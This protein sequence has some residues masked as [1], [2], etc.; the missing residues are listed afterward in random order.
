MMQSS[1]CIM[2]ENHS[3]LNL[4]IL[5]KLYVFTSNLQVTAFQLFYKRNHL[6][7]KIIFHESFV[8]QTK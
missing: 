6:I 2:Q 5:F 8:V 3:Y 4:L 7:V 1:L